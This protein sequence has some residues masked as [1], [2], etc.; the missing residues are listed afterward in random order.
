MSRELTYRPH[1][2][3]RVRRLAKVED[4]QDAAGN[5]D[6]VRLA[7]EVGITA[8]CVKYILTGALP[9]GVATEQPE[10]IFE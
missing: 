4:F 2:A 7:S 10:D 6:Y 9:P 5:P 3:R 8:T 1:H